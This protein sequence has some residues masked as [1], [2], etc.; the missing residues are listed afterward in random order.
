MIFMVIIMVDGHVWKYLGIAMCGLFVYSF[1]ENEN[2]F[3]KITEY[4]WKLH[5]FRESIIK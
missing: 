5:L 3:D 4:F 2:M 1:V